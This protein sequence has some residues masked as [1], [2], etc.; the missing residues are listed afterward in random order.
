MLPHEARPLARKLALRWPPLVVVDRMRRSWEHQRD[1]ARPRAKR[2]CSIEMG[3]K[4]G[5]RNQSADTL[6]LGETVSLSRRLRVRGFRDRSGGVARFIARR[7]PFAAPELFEADGHAAYSSKDGSHSVCVALRKGKAARASRD[8]DGF[9][10]RR[11][12]E[13]TLDG[14]AAARVEAVRAAL[15][16]GPADWL[17]IAAAAVLMGIA[18]ARTGYGFFWEDLRATR[19][20]PRRRDRHARRGLHL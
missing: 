3:T 13:A 2:R 8:C 14:R 6:R 19:C 18:V 9:E 11:C 1:G 20:V 4:R 16:A 12:A 5:K 7:R 15:A 17:A 10:T